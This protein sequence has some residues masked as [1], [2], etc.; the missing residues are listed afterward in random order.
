MI[1]EDDLFWVALADKKLVGTI[2]AGYDGHRGWIY[3]LA[4]DENYRK[5][6]IGSKLLRHAEK[7][8]SEIGCMKVNL[9]ILKKN[10]AVKDFY[11]NSGYAEEERISMGKILHENVPIDINK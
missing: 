9:Q 5:Q 11:L 8:L 4:V 10:V 3:S 2:M 6:N 1:T 7:R